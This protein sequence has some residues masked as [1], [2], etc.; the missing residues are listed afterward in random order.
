LKS[1]IIVDKTFNFA[2]NIAGLYKKLKQDREFIVGSQLFRAA[3]SIGANVEEAQAAQ[4][5]KDFINK[6]SIA[7]KEAR[8]T[9]YWLRVI[10][11][12][13]LIEFDLTSQLNDINEIISI[14]TSII[15]TTSTNVPVSK[16]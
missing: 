2:V 16:N 9:R 12:A 1:N 5:R 15:K 6:M 4:S 3:T 14:L 7:S 8:E 11:S 10:S 13:Q